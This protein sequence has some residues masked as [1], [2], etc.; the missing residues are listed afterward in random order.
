MSV[1][2]PPTTFRAWI[3]SVLCV[4]LSA[5]QPD[6][7][8]A[9]V[10][11]SGGYEHEDLARLEKI[12]LLSGFQYEIQDR[13][14]PERAAESVYPWRYQSGGVIYSYFN[15]SPDGADRLRAIL[16]LN[17]STGRLSVRISGG[18]NCPSKGFTTGARRSI[19]ELPPQIK[20]EFG[21]KI[22]VKY[23]DSE[24]CGGRPAAAP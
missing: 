13:S 19:E 9:E 20:S 16:S 8:I 24:R 18:D 12:F 4:F 22:Q 15:Y 5:C 1:T 6:G 2:T 17:E 3:L 10:H 23:I 7:P 11:L 14:S 21:H